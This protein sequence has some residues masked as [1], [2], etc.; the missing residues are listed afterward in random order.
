MFM[1]VIENKIT[2]NPETN[3]IKK[4]LQ[5][6]QRINIIRRN[7]VI[8]SFQ[9]TL[10]YYMEVNYLGGNMTRKYRMDEKSIRIIP[11]TGEK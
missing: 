5:K 8:W 9:H 2:H 6:P 1:F 11:F 7:K 10:K 3:K 4:T